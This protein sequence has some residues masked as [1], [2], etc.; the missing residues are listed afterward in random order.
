MSEFTCT[1]CGSPL[2]N[3]GKG[4]CCPNG[5]GKMKPPLPR[6]IASRN[7]AIVAGCQSGKRLGFS[8]QATLDSSPGQIVKLG[9]QYTGP[10]ANPKKH[11][12]VD[13]K[14]YPYTE[15]FEDGE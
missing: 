10:R 15:D 7:H 14:I 6:D 5:H 1:E 3:C 4:S 2:I 11:I 12:V 13:G 9:R 8:D